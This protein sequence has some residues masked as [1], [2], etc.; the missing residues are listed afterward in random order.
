MKILN[1]ISLTK[2]SGEEIIA[3]AKDVFTEW[4]D[5]DFKNWN[6]TSKSAKTKK[7]EL[8]VCEMTEDATFTKFFAEPEKMALTQSQ[9][10]A[11]C[12]DHSKELNQSGNNFFLF[13]EKNDFFVARVRLCGAGPFVGVYR[14]SDDYVWGAGYRDR[15]VLP[16]LA[17]S[18][19]SFDSLTLGRSGTLP[20]S[21]IINGI[22]YERK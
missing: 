18:V 13:K 20:K 16:Q 17:T 19:S 2:T 10:I 3:D 14:L 15:V 22:T 11:F 8:A 21:L 1:T 7:T 5:K 6:L 4:V 9:I 12:K